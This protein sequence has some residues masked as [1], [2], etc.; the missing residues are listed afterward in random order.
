MGRKSFHA[1]L[2]QIV[3][4]KYGCHTI[5]HPSCISPNVTLTPL[6]QCWDLCLL[7]LKVAFVIVSI[8]RMAEWGYVIS[9]AGHKRQCSFH[10]VLWNYTRVLNHL[11]SS[12]TTLEPPHWVKAQ[13]R[14]HWGN[15]GTIEKP[16]NT[17]QLLLCQ[18]QSSPDYRR[19]RDRTTQLSPSWTPDPKKPWDHK[20][21]ATELCH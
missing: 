16:E 14:P 6:S 19:P 5:S 9:K 4:F 1:P 18:I 3:F 15:E 10:L 11:A 2:Q 7:V 17:G 21:T 12:L 13:T 8:K 20:I